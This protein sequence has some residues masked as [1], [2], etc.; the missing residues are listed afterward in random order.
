M[1]LHGSDY[2]HRPVEIQLLFL[3]WTSS[4]FYQQQLGRLMGHMPPSPSVG[5]PDLPDLDHVVDIYS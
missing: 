2:L 4:I 1:G 3:G 5:H